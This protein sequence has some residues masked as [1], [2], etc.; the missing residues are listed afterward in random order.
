MTNSKDDETRN[1]KRGRWISCE[2]LLPN[3]GIPVVILA[4]GDVPLEAIRDGAEEWRWR[5]ERADVPRSEVMHWRPKPES[6]LEWL[7]SL[8]GKER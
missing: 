7:L 4:S 8:I 3:P 6:E 5:G 1:M 2:D